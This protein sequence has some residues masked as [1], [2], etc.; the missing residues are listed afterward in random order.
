MAK[1]RS[2]TKI[3]LVVIAL[4]LV[5]VVGY[6]A[7]SNVL[8]KAD[9]S[10]NITNLPSYTLQ[11]GINYIAFGGTIVP[12]DASKLI[13]NRTAYRYNP[14]LKDKSGN[15]GGWEKLNK[16]NYIPKP[17]ESF[18]IFST[19]KQETWSPVNVASFAPTPMEF[20]S[21]AIYPGWNMVANPYNSVYYLSQLEVMNHPCPTPKPG[22]FACMA[23]GVV[24]SYADSRKA[25]EVSS[26]Y[27]WNKEVKD[28]D[29]VNEISPCQKAQKPDDPS[30]EPSCPPA[31]MFSSL[32]PKAGAWINNKTQQTR[33][34]RFVVK[35]E[36]VSGTENCV[37]PEQTRIDKLTPDNS[38][39]GVA[40]EVTIT[41]QNLPSVGVKV[42]FGD[43]TVDPIQPTSLSTLKFKV[44]T[45][46]VC[47]E[48]A[49]C[50]GAP[51]P[52][53][54]YDV[55]LEVSGSEAKSINSNKL[56]YTII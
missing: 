16:T 21:V 28:W 18:Y 26:F 31:S 50:F 47:P 38:P 32:A 10:S 3:T 43:K 56:K 39:I 25:G 36:C 46:G 35:T 15:T 12:S 6:F 51:L 53:G 17:G 14:Q 9:T 5:A 27:V 13:F 29:E 23:E 19:K 1:K 45:L 33:Q 24:Q 2:I 8:T 41:G 42:H 22:E 20:H 30:Y 54:E 37:L 55:W 48:N 44:P 11:R 7:W 40:Q 52:A 4:V 34:L 49:Q